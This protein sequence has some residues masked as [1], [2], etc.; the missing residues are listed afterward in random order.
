[1]QPI[2]FLAEARSISNEIIYLRRQIHQWPEL[3]KQEF[4]TSQLVV[5]YLNNLGISTTNLCGTGVVGVLEGEHPGAVVALRADMD[6]LPIE[7]KNDVPYRSQREGIMHACGHDCHTAALL[8]SAKLLAT[9]RKE[10]PGTVKFIFQPDEE[11]DGGAAPM[12]EAGALENPKVTAIFGAHV[13]S[14]YPAGHVGTIVG[15]FCAASNPFKITVLGR[16]AHG[17]RP[18]QGVDAIMIT[19]QIL[20]ALQCYISREVDPLDS[21]LISVGTIRGGTRSNVVAEEVTLSGIIRTLDADLRKKTTNAVQRIACGVA[22]IFGGQAIVKIEESFAA[23]FN[24][25]RMTK[26]V[27]RSICKLFG[28]DKHISIERPSMG[29]E[30]MGAFL[31]AVPGCFYKMGVRDDSAGFVAPAHSDR[32]MVQE[33]ALPDLSALH[34]QVVFDY[35]SSC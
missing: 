15:K 28:E 27:D 34:A 14:L 19:A 10:L 22:D 13:S 20:T 33:S 29:T 25:A 9:H 18:H 21:A 4:R 35:L 3:G 16:N 24:D 31:A 23:G 8:G 7:E 1:M 12:I 5:Q 17:A 11:G 6:A 30:D 2:N 32:F 26:L